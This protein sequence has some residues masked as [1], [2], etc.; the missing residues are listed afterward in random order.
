MRRK[1]AST[2]RLGRCLPAIVD[3][4]GSWSTRVAMRQQ[5]VADALPSDT[6][7]QAKSSPGSTTPAELEFRTGIRQFLRWSELAAKG[8][9]ITPAQH[10]LL[11]AVRGHPDPQGASIS[12]LAEYL[13]LGYQATWD[14]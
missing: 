6:S 11:L 7:G 5:V 1:V 8:A 14:W 10:Q 3:A 9:C 13:V 2:G 4:G 12:D